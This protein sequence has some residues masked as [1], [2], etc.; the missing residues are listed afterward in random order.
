VP[1]HI[2]YTEYSIHKVHGQ[3][4]SNSLKL[5]IEMIYKKIFFR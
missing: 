5:W 4:N 3:K 2:R 1:V